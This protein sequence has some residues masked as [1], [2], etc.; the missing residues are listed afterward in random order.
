MSLLAQSQLYSWLLLKRLIKSMSH[1]HGLFIKW[2]FSHTVL[3]TNFLT[4]CNMDR[5]RIFQVS[6]HCFPFTDK[7]LLQLTSFLSPFTLSIQEEQSHFFI[8]CIGIPSTT[9]PI[10]LLR[11]STFHKTLEHPSAR[12]FATLEQGLLFLPFP[13]RSSSL[14]ESSPVSPLTFL[15]HPSGAPGWLRA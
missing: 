13:T 5:L 15:Q 11:S 7:F 4:F 1:T 8:L 12:F 2:L 14:S 6:K 10:P 9:Y 3:F